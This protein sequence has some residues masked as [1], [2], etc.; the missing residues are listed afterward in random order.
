MEQSAINIR[1]VQGKPYA[2]IIDVCTMLGVAGQFGSAPNALLHLMAES[3]TYQA[4]L[5]R[6]EEQNHGSEGN[7]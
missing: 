6:L 2:D 4:G 3:P 1:R 5:K 7:A